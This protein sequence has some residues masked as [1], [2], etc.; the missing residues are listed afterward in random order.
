MQIFNSQQIETIHNS[1]FF[2]KIPG[3]ESD[4]STCGWSIPQQFHVQARFMAW[5]DIITPPVSQFWQA[6]MDDDLIRLVAEHNL[7]KD[8]DKGTKL[9][10]LMS[11]NVPVEYYERRYCYLMKLLLTRGRFFV[12]DDDR[13]SA[14]LLDVC[15]TNQSIKEEEKTKKAS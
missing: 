13:F 15:S 6:E 4:I 14:S 1:G 2:I 8:L 9:K 7:V 11:K 10:F 3:V 5:E 12:K